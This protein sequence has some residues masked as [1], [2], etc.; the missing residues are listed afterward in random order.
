MAAGLMAFSLSVCLAWCQLRAPGGI[1]K[2]R[3]GAENRSNDIP[4]PFRLSVIS[5]AF[6]SC[7]KTLQEPALSTVYPPQAPL[8]HLESTLSY[9]P[10]EE[11]STL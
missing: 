8:L 4:E 1:Q 7:I 6:H 10:T 2:R 9:M 3:M 5:S 11:V